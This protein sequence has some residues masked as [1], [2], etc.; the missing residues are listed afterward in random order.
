MS[1]PKEHIDQIIRIAEGNLGAMRVCCELVEHGRADL[2]NTLEQN[3]V[4]GSQVWELY[5]DRNWEEVV[6]VIHELD[7]QN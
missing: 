4:R 5:K 2:L 1:S 6:N 3:Q 7:S